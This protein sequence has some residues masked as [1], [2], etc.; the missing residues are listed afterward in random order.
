MRKFIYAMIGFA[1]L[2]GCAVLTTTIYFWDAIQGQRKFDKLCKNEGGARYYGPVEKNVGWL[3]EG[4]LSGYPDYTGPF[5]FENVLFVR[6]T[7][8]KGEQFDA[9]KRSGQKVKSFPRNGEEDF[10]LMPVDEKKTVRYK[11]IF[12]RKD[13]PDDNRINRDQDQIVDLM[14]G[15]IVATF[16]GFGYQWTKPENVILNAPTGVT[17]NF[18]Y[19]NYRDF[20]RS[21]Y[22]QGK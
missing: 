21:I 10:I 15:K 2:V 13:M 7:N 1:I 22:N 17:C 14:T 11:L 4:P 16:T 20:R 3:V 18:T 8:T 9:Y 5:Q 6:W 19:E 12:E